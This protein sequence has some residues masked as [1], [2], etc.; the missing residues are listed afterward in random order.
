MPA[1]RDRVKDV[2]EKFQVPWRFNKK[3]KSE[4]EAGVLGRT[5]ERTEA[6]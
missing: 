3:Q 4:G 2:L 1:A 5:E 6:G